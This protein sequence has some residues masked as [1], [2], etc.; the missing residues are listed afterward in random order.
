MSIVGEN[1]VISRTCKV[2]LSRLRA[3]YVGQHT[4]GPE[5]RQCQISGVR[6]QM[7]PSRT[8]GERQWMMQRMGTTWAVG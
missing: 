8:E 2:D 6:I 5:N 1:Q 7:R 4:D 3:R